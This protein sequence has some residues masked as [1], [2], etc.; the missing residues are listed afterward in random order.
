MTSQT[1]IEKNEARADPVAFME[2]NG[3]VFAGMPTS[4][5]AGYA[6]WW[7]FGVPAGSFLQAVIE[8]D[9]YTS[10]TCADETNLA[11]L[12][13]IVRWF[14]NK[15]DVR[16]IRKNAKSWGDDGGRFGRLLELENAKASKSVDMF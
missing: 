1:Q 16:S 14:W 15:A 3:F 2:S 13:D 5:R 10:I 4:L 6:R 8:G 7:C 11:R 9:L 12:H